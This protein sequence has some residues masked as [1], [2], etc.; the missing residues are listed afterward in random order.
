MARGALRVCIWPDYFA[1]SFRN[2]RNDALEGIV[3]HVQQR[4][5]DTWADVTPT[6]EPPRH[7]LVV[8]GVLAWGLFAFWGHRVLIGVA[9]L[10]ART[11][12][13]LFVRGVTQNRP[14]AACMGV[15]TARISSF[16]FFR[17]V[18]ISS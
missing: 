4:I 10:I 1:I 8:A 5:G 3:V 7:W 9:L 15:N 18:R 12:L 2:P 13:G 17:I 11:R 6:I 16:C 14:M